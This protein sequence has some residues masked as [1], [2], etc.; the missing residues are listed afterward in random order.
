MQ[1]CNF[2]VIMEFKWNIINLICKNNI[3]FSYNLSQ[4]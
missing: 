4:K 1:I 2:D 3:A